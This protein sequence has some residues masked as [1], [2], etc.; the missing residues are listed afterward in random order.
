[1]TGSPDLFETLSYRLVRDR[2]NCTVWDP[3]RGYYG[4]VTILM[5]RAYLHMPTGNEVEAD[6]GSLHNCL[7]QR[8]TSVCIIDNVHFCNQ[9]IRKIVELLPGGYRHEQ[10]SRTLR[11]GQLR[12]A[13][14]VV[15][16]VDGAAQ[17][18]VTDHSQA[19][20]DALLKQGAAQGD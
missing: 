19:A 20:V 5:F 4:G 17:V 3:K 7:Q 15:D 8:F 18:Q 12:Y 2:R 11:D 13:H 1:M 10:C 14:G 6:C 9:I 16:G